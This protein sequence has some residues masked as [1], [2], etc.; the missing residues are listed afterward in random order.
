MTNET[1]T[2]WISE[3]LKKLATPTQYE[4]LP[5]LKLTPN[6]VAEVEVDSSKPF[7]EWKEKDE[8]GQVITTKKIIPVIVSGARLNWWLNVKNP[9]YREIIEAISLGQNKFKILQTGTKKETRY[10]LVK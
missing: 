2:N 9:I 1:Q 10:N 4:E 3:E 7:Q 8:K 6:V 5:S